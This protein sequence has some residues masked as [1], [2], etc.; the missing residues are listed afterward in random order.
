[1][2]SCELSVNIDINVP[3]HGFI[4]PPPF[5]LGLTGSNGVTEHAR[6]SRSSSELRLYSQERQ[7][8]S[9]RG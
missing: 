3:I 7:R 2:F 1:M 5:Y 8:V 9:Q 4:L 6:N